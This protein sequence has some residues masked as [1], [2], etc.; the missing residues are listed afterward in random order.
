[1]KKVKVW[2]KTAINVYATVEVEED[3]TMDDILDAAANELSSLTGYAG[4]GGYDKLCGVSGENVGLECDY[5]E[6]EWAPQGKE[7]IEVV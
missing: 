2:G 3:A 1:M 6:I 5:A 7:D 4:N